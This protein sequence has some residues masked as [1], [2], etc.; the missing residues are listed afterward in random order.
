MS[1]TITIQGLEFEVATPFAEGHTC[2]EAEA[3]ALNQTRAENI[4]NNTARAVKEAKEKHGDTLPDNVV[5]ELTDLVAKYDSEYVFTLANAGGG[6]RSLDP[7]EREARSIAR[8]ALRAKLKQDGRKV[9]KADEAPTSEKDVTKE[10]FDEAVEKLA[11][12]EDIVKLAT[13]TVKDREKIDI[14]V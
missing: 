9:L 12:R 4:R 2:T 14:T 11:E 7:V 8:T 3:K 5:Q 10:A 6:T 1:K 13:K